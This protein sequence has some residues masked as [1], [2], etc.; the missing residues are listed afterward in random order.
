MAANVWTKWTEKKIDQLLAGVCVVKELV[1]AINC[2]HT[3][4]SMEVLVGI[5]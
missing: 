2:V 5:F 4:V 3:P 1:R